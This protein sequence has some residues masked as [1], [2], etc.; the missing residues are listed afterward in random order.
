MDAD[1]L[2]SADR[3]AGVETVDSFERLYRKHVSAVLRYAMRCVGRMDVAEELTSDAFIALYNNLKRIDQSRLPAWLYTVVRNAAR[4]HWRHSQLE[5][6]YAQPAEVQVKPEEPEILSS[7][8][9]IPELKPVHRACLILRYAHDMD[10]ADIAS[11]LGLTENQVK[12]ALQYGL[13]LLRKSLADT[14]EVR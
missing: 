11:R 2:S 10:R 6:K 7:I 9:D 14:R 3:V 5:L 4:S 12:S 1:S 8:L 13:E